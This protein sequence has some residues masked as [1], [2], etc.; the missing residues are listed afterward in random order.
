M[1]SV[2]CIGGS[3]PQARG[4]RFTFHWLFPL[5]GLIPAGAGRT[6]HRQDR[7]SGTWAHPRRRG[8]DLCCQV[9][10]PKVIGS[11]PQARGGQVLEKP[12]IDPSGLIPAGAGRTVFPFLCFALWTAH[13]RRRGEDHR[14]RS[15]APRASGSSPQARG[16]LTLGLERDGDVGLIPAGAG[17]TPGIMGRKPHNTAHPRRRGEDKQAFAEQVNELGSSPQARGGRGY[18][19][20]AR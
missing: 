3:S 18:V 16:G 7:R 19:S 14:L 15:Q 8:E 11:S 13:P 20:S 1:R 10:A 12:A 9:F 4:G 6:N 17:R 5:V 2:V